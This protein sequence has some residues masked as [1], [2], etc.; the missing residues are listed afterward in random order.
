LF[1]LPQIG[2]DSTNLT[3]D[4]KLQNYSDLIKKGSLEG[5][6]IKI[7]VGNPDFVQLITLV[8]YIIFF[9]SLLSCCLYYKQIKHIPINLRVIEQKLLLRQS[10]LLVLFNDPLF[11]MIFYKPNG[12]Q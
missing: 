1:Y 9:V 6:E 7:K 2:V 11:A 3:I 4:L 10:I 8:K 12:L 5:L